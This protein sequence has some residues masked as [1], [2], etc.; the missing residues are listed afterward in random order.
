[1]FTQMTKAEKGFSVATFRCKGGVKDGPSQLES[2]ISCN[3]VRKVDGSYYCTNGE[4]ILK[5]G[6]LFQ[7][8]LK[9]DS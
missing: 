6:D 5:R 7:A 1:M 3:A 2:L 4:L 9:A 8:D